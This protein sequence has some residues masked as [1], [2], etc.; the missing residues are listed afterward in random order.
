MS[1]SSDLAVD[2]LPP[3]V[4][5]AVRVMET[6]FAVTCD[7]MFVDGS[8]QVHKGRTGRSLTNQERVTWAMSMHLLAT[9]F[10]VEESEIEAALHSADDDVA[11]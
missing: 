3:Q 2:S 6:L 7:Q 9:F 10:R 1:D 4:S 5:A 8:G 11:D